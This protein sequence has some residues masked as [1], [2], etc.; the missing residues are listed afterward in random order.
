RV[1]DTTS[2]ALIVERAGHQPNFSPTSRFIAA[3]GGS[4]SDIDTS[5]FEIVDLYSGEVAHSFK[6]DLAE[7]GE[8]ARGFQFGAIAWGL[9]DSV[10]ILGYN[11][12]G[13]IQVRQALIGRDPTEISSDTCHACSP[14]SDPVRLDSDNLAVRI[15]KN[16]V[17]DTWADAMLG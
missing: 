2:G 4:R 17:A 10:V 12:F 3:F 15:V 7:E 13:N 5:A 8:F 16:G 11:V 1:L 6:R 14:R 9:A